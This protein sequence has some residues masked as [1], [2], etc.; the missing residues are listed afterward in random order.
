MGFA[1]GLSAAACDDGDEAP[2]D[3]PSGDRVI[4][5]APIDEL[6]LI[7]RE[8]F[9][10]QYAV[11]IVSGLPNGCAQ[12]H[13]VELVSQGATV[14]EFRVENSVPADPDT[15]CTAIYGTHE[16]IMELGAGLGSGIEYTVKV[17]DKELKFTAQ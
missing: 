11:R 3:A 1:L 5:L 10:A 14:F 16:Q 15:V 4:Q 9:P 2:G 13:S 17:N 6:E 12:F 8:S 7:I